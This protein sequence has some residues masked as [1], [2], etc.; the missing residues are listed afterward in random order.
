MKT[1]YL[2]EELDKNLTKKLRFILPDGREVQGDLHFTEIKSITINS[3][4]CGSNSHS[5]N[6]TVIQLWLNERSAKQAEWPG[7]KAVNILNKVGSKQRFDLESEVY[8]EYGDSITQTA[9]YSIESLNQVGEDLEVH[10]FVKPTECKP[11]RNMELA[12]C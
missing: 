12:C 11:R 4:D 3:M 6:E 1:K 2:F 5:F 10:L 7:R 8:F 9:K